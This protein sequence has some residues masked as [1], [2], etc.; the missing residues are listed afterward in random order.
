MLCPCGLRPG[1]TGAGRWERAAWSLRMGNLTGD[2]LP[3]RHRP[4]ECRSPAEYRV[5]CVRYE[6]AP[7]MAI[8]ATCM[9]I[10]VGLGVALGVLIGMVLLVVV[11]VL[12]KKRRRREFLSRQN[13]L[14]SD[15]SPS[16]DHTNNKLGDRGSTLAP[17]GVVRYIPD[18]SFTAT[19]Q[20][21][22]QQPDLEEEHPEFTLLTTDCLDDDLGKPCKV[23]TCPTRCLDK[24]C[25]YE[26]TP[27]NIISAGYPVWQQTGNPADKPKLDIFAK[28]SCHNVPDARN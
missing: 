4:P 5:L 27:G 16:R 25:L 24:N 21:K 13:T 3:A 26:T 9:L 1:R 14:L 28:D 19:I 17:G 8:N 23:S 7:Q 6:P 20:L 2:R 18:H 12:M 11:F 22:R 15:F 10:V